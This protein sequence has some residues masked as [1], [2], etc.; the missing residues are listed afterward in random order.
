M[1]SSVQ[2]VFLFDVN[3]FAQTCKKESELE[4][5]VAKLKLTCLRLLTEFGAQT[6]VVRWSCKYYDSCSFKPDTSRRDFGEFSKQSF[7]D[8]ENEL[9]DRYCKAFDGIHQ[10][11]GDKETDFDSRE[12][13][14]DKTTTTSSSESLKPHSYILKK[15]LQEV[16]LDYNWDQPDISSPVKSTRRRSKTGQQKLI[17]ENVGPYNTIVIFT[18]VPESGPNLQE[19]CGLS[20]T[21][22]DVCISPED[23]LGSILDPSMVKGFQ[24]DKKISL[25]FVS[26]CDFGI[27]KDPQYTNNI[28]SGLGKLNGALHNITS[29]VQSSPWQV[30]D[31]PVPDASETNAPSSLF[32]SPSV[33]VAGLG[34]PLVWWG[35]GKVGRPRKPQPGPLLVWEDEQ[36]TSHLRAQLEVLAVHGSCS[37]QWGSAS[38][39]GVVRSGAVSVLAVAGDAGH[40][41]VCHAPNTIFNILVQVLAKHHLSMMVKLSCGGVGVLSPW[42]GGVGCLA[43]MSASGLATPPLHPPSSSSHTS[44]VPGLKEHNLLKFVAVTVRK[45]LKSAAAYNGGEP[46]PNTKRFTPSHTQPWFIPTP[47]ATNALNHIK[48]R[49]N[50][51]MERRA[52]Q[53]RLQRRYLPQIPPPLAAGEV[54]VRDLVDM[55]QPP[56]DPLTQSTPGTQPTQGTTAV[57]PT[58]TRA[59]QLVKK[60]HI[61]TA[62]QKVKEQRAE[63]QE[64][65]QETERRA[66]QAEEQARKSQALES[67]VLNDVSNPEDTQELVASLVRLREGVGQMGSDLFTTAQTIVNLALSHVRATTSAPTQ[68]E[69]GL[70]KVLG[71]G[72][73]QTAKEINSSGVSSDTHLYLCQLHTLLHLELLWILGYSSSNKVEDDDEESELG[74]GDGIRAYHLDEIVRLLRTVSLRHDPTAMAK[75]LQDTVLENSY[76]N[77]LGEVLVEI[78]E[79]LNQPLPPPLLALMGE[80]LDS[81]SEIKPH[82]VKSQSSPIKSYESGGGGSNN[83]GSGKCRG[84]GRR[85]LTLPPT[86]KEASKR[87]IVVPKLTRALS[88][89][90]SEQ[91]HSHQLTAVAAPPPPSKELRKRNNIEKARRNL[92]D[93][94]GGDIGGGGSGTKRKL[95][96]SRTVSGTSTADCKGK[97]KRGRS[98]GKLATNT[99]GKTIHF[100]S[101]IPGKGANKTPVKPLGTREKG[102]KTPKLKKGELVPETPGEKIGQ[103][104]FT[105]HR[106][107]KSTGTT[108]ISES[109]D[110]KRLCKTTPRRLRASLTVTRRNSFYSGARSRNWERARTQMLADH[111]RSHSDPQRSSLEP[112][113]PSTSRDASFLFSEIITN[114]ST[115][116]LNPGRM[117][118]RKGCS[119]SQN[120]CVE[121]KRDSISWLPE[122]KVLDFGLDEDDL[123]EGQGMSE[124][125]QNMAQIGFGQDLRNTPVKRARRALSLGTPSKLRVS[126]EQSPSKAS[127]LNSSQGSSGSF[128]GFLTPGKEKFS[129]SKPLGLTTESPSTPSRPQV[130]SGIFGPSLSAVTP[131]K[132]VQFTLTLTPKKYYTSP[133]PTHTQGSTC[134]TP[135]TGTPKSILKTPGKTPVKSPFHNLEAT[136][137]TTRRSSHTPL[138]ISKYRQG[139]STPSKKT[140]LDFNND[141]DNIPETPTSKRMTLANSPVKV[142]NIVSYSESEI[143]L[144]SPSKL[145]KTSQKS[146]SNRSPQKTNFMNNLTEASPQ[147]LGLV[148]SACVG[149][150]VDSA[151]IDPSL[152]PHIAPE[153]IEMVSEL[154]FSSDL[155]MDS[156]INEVEMDEDA[157]LL[158]VNLNDIMHSLPTSPEYQEDAHYISPDKEE[159][160]ANRDFLESKQQMTPT[161]TISG[162]D[163]EGCLSPV[164]PLD[165][166]VRMNMEKINTELRRPAQIDYIEEEDGEKEIKILPKCSFEDEQLQDECLEKEL[167]VAADYCNVISKQVGGDVSQDIKIDRSIDKKAQQDVKYCNEKD[168]QEKFEVSDQEDQEKKTEVSETFNEVDENSKG[169]HKEKEDLKTDE[170]GEEEQ[171]DRETENKYDE[172]EW[173]DDD[174]D[175]EEDTEQEVNIGE[176]DN[177]W[178]IED[179]ES[180]TE[181]TSNEIENNDEQEKEEK[182]QEEIAEDDKAH[183]GV[184]NVKSFQAL[185]SRDSEVSENSRSGGSPNTEN[186]VSSSHS[187]KKKKSRSKSNELVRTSEI[188]SR[189]DHPQEPEQKN[190]QHFV[191]KMKNKREIHT[192]EILHSCEH[193]R[194]NEYDKFMFFNSQKKRTQESD[195]EWEHK[196]LKTEKQT[197]PRLLRKR[198]HTNLEKEEEEESE[199][200]NVS[201]EICLK[202]SGLEKEVDDNGI[203][204]ENM[205]KDNDR[206]M[207]LRKRESIKIERQQDRTQRSCRKLITSLRELSSEDEDEYY[208]YTNY[209]D[210]SQE[211]IGKKS[212]RIFDDDSDFISPLKSAKKTM[213]L[214]NVENLPSE[215]S[216]KIPGQSDDFVTLKELPDVGRL[217]DTSPT[218]KIKTPERHRQQ[219]IDTYLSPIS[220]TSDT[221]DIHALPPPKVVSEVTATQKL[222]EIAGDF[223]IMRRRHVNR[224]VSKVDGCIEKDNNSKKCNLSK[225]TGT[226]IKKRKKKGVKMKLTKSGKHYEVS[227]TTQISLDSSDLNTSE[228]KSLHLNMTS[229]N[230]SSFTL[231]LDSSFASSKTETPILKRKKKKNKDKDCY[232]S[233]LETNCFITPH[234]FTRHMSKDLSISP[235]LFQK[236]ITLS[237]VKTNPMASESPQN[238]HELRTKTGKEVK[239]SST[240]QPSAHMSSNI[241]ACKDV[242]SP[243][244]KRKRSSE[245]AEDEWSV[246]SLPGSPT[247]KTFTRKQKIMHSIKKSPRI[248]ISSFVERREET[249]IEDESQAKSTRQSSP[250]VKKNSN[251]ISPSL[252]SLI[253][254]A[255]SPILTGQGSEGNSKY[256]SKPR[257]S[258]RL[259]R[260]SSGDGEGQ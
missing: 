107:R 248:N 254:L 243:S 247:M 51:R 69:E 24:V 222:S 76:M 23:F 224:K 188:K 185:L 200:H 136:T 244:L 91:A 169:K 148:D 158:Q 154:M 201:P 189:R 226:G 140:R 147:K 38:V 182:E 155:N 1:F 116:S 37:R 33:H 190:E 75:F 36:G 96:R 113:Q 124:R 30:A 114:S 214:K 9:I 72:V 61:V 232:S 196:I 12:T 117:E 77:T 210:W 27:N 129:V 47:A 237:P 225:H 131:S 60:S 66:A 101:T 230:S 31:E 227:E 99:P 26:V 29:I 111:L 40:L 152:M 92:F 126:M 184:K 112:A 54:G 245:V 216:G 223:K 59:Q 233:P 21:V 162:S 94:D 70:R 5:N 143:E 56:T 228:D 16:L 130:I 64:R 197:S 19:F 179:S 97:K 174:V 220:K 203:D 68:M 52:M 167:N 212:K 170:E 204:Q 258:R 93:L 221:R 80:D 218:R 119:S 142:D 149:Q 260:A 137:P 10:S 84:D 121:E 25:N 46:A 127:P 57:R 199:E 172:N 4:Q 178:G 125:I 120:L 133:K 103:T 118:S 135:C 98:P 42:A 239:E 67:Q 65:V 3:S 168:E 128:H 53:E 151:E 202:F 146:F 256:I 164:I 217:N 86:L 145:R 213:P 165:P 44:Y 88:R 138:K 83:P 171:E 156:D 48:K 90:M 173:D 110:I 176:H 63:E 209:H 95:H 163:S 89:T 234:R 192:E 206:R 41:Y 229:G 71:D 14:A 49:S 150:D 35:R 8:F 141:D 240:E 22:K 28:Q 177:K 6:E 259:Y 139:N 207:R 45:C 191:S 15:A 81:I 115:S 32:P 73:L 252:M 194:R 181:E 20:S 166:I 85:T 2:A 43:V 253:H 82:S 39:I 58:L 132:R 123:E 160:S 79:E 78:Y 109:P 215:K 195:E 219:K 100:T 198:K 161:R 87:S 255:V 106:I 238:N 175:V 134:G 251:F 187:H 193:E 186:S 246:R 242:S 241:V 17:P 108:T 55:T 249:N 102:Q 211:K 157:E 235:E 144:L 231:A 13:T 74:R 153:D 257:S 7:D 122:K 159:I 62:Q 11:G 18:S 105:Q 205:R 104:I 183:P 180:D 208:D 50:S 236:L 250:L 34:I